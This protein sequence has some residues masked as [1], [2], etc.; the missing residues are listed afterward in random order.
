LTRFR[1]QADTARQQ[2]RQQVVLANCRSNRPLSQA[3][4]TKRPR[5]SAR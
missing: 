2:Q 4:E 5:R 1:A 3:H